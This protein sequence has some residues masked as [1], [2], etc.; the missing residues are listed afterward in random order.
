[1]NVLVLATKFHAIEDYERYMSKG[2]LPKTNVTYMIEFHGQEK[3]NQMPDNWIPVSDFANSSAV[4]I[5]MA[6][7]KNRG[8][9]AAVISYDEV[10]LL[11]AAKIRDAYGVSGLREQEAL[12]FRDKVVMKE[13][14]G[15]KKI[16][17]PKVFSI[18]QLRTGHYHLPLVGKPRSLAG[19]EGVRIFTDAASLDAV[20]LTSYE[21][22]VELH[23]ELDPNDLQFEEYIDGSIFH[24]DGIVCE[25]KLVYASTSAYIGT[26]LD[27]LTG[28]PLASQM[29]PS[30]RHA[31]EWSTYAQTIVEA[32]EI[33][34]GVF[35]LEAFQS[36]AGE[37]IFLEIGLRP[38]GGL[39][40]PSL[41]K[42]RGIDLQLIHL[43]AQLQMP[44]IVE[45]IDN[46]LAGFILL[47][48]N[49]GLGEDS[50]R[51][52]SHFDCKRVEVMTSFVGESKHLQLKKHPQNSCEFLFTSQHWDDI[53]LSLCRL[54]AAIRLERSS[55]CP[56]KKLG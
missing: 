29:L 7:I 1:M 15:A 20:L 25:G 19:S 5:A 14:L 23:S 30:G 22:N 32:M 39:V 13:V 9:F 37:R 38:G 53:S 49:S 27:Y 36:A 28:E 8:P 31:D 33:P 3:P 52:S 21:Q 54:L 10:S 56:L 45:T 2:D 40:V 26:C 24:I 48:K 34:N 42:V 55:L 16:R 6:E 41:Q 17:V 12:K 11:T 4:T 35:H 47:P 51:K 18:E 50:I 44:F 43:Q 46:G